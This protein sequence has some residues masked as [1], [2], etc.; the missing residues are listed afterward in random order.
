MI[1]GRT[2]A[3][4]PPVVRAKELVAVPPAAVPPRCVPPRAIA[5]APGSSLAGPPAE[6]LDRPLSIGA[7]AAPPPASTAATICSW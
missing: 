5:S 1:T 7:S 4:P 6:A 3:P 2:G